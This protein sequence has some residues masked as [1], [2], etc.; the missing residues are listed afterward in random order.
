MMIRNALLTMSLAALSAASAMADA[1]RRGVIRLDETII[2]G[3]QELP[4]V[5]YIVPW[6]DPD[7]M[8]NIELDPEFAELEVFRR[9]YPPAYRRE[10]NYYELLNAVENQE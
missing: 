2:S 10:L 5:L 1:E 9:L 7:G 8:P 3:N 6:K 4:K